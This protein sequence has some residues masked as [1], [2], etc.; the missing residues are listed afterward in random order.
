MKNIKVLA[1]NISEILPKPDKWFYYLCPSRAKKA[2][3][4]LRLND[5]ARCVAAGLLLAYSSAKATNTL[6]QEIVETRYSNNK[7]RLKNMSGFHFNISHSAD[8]VVCASSDIELGVDIEKI[9]DDLSTVAQKYYCSSELE[10][11]STLPA[12]QAHRMRYNLWTIKESIMKA[13]GMGFKLPP[14]QICV[15]STNPVKTQITSQQKNYTTQLT[16]FQDD[17]SLAMSAREKFSYCLSIKTISE[18]SE[19]LSN[20]F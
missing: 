2:Q 6:K 4:Y 12:N 11:I 10:M 15:L 13:S 17:Y 8:W 18:I 9:S 19:F 5:C 3:R 1:L 7:P 14:Q 16:N 20:R